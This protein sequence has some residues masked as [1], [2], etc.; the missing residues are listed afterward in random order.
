MKIRTFVTLAF[1]T[2]LVGTLSISAAAADWM[3]TADIPFA[4]QVGSTQ[5]PAGLYTFSRCNNNTTFLIRS[6][7]GKA[8]VLA[9]GSPLDS[10]NPAASPRV[11]V[12][13]YGDRYFV[14]RIVLAGGHSTQLSKSKVET[15][16]QASVGGGSSPLEVVAVQ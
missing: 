3:M 14:G 2:V 16:Y 6:T 5:M 9:F 7:D 8:S 12:N 4:F 11:V 13:H 1:A 10:S 15:E